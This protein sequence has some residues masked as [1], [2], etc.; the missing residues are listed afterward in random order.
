MPRSHLTLSELDDLHRWVSRA[1]G[2]LQ[3][4][5]PSKALAHELLTTIETKM[6]CERDMWFWPDLSDVPT[7]EIVDEMMSTEAPYW[8]NQMAL[9]AERARLEDEI[10]RVEE[11]KRRKEEEEWEIEGL[12]E[13]VERL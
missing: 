10:A 1:I 7:S 3:Q 11:A 6:R 13:R 8:R 2:D 4:N 9:A 12:A 5:P